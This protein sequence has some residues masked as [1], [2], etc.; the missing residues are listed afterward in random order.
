M[1]MMIEKDGTYIN[2]LLP[3]TKKKCFLLHSAMCG[4]KFSLYW[5]VLEHLA[6]RE[7]T[8]STLS[9]LKS[10]MSDGHQSSLHG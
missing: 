8:D 7:M 3:D 2:P 10:R 9:K 6:P 5:S 1:Y 4:E